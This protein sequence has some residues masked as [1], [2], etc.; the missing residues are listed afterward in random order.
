MTHKVL[1]K[2][3]TFNNGDEVYIKLW[4]DQSHVYLAGFDKNDNRVTTAIY[5][6]E[7]DMA[8]DFYAALKES[9]AAS[10]EKTIVTDL[11]SA[12]DLHY[13]PNTEIR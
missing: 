2:T 8:D 10:L 6:A 5:S 9:L 7:V 3:L 4:T 11:E 12:P 1:R 13:R